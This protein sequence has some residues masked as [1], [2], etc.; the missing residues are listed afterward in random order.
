[1][2]VIVGAGLL[3]VDWRRMRRKRDPDDLAKVER[4]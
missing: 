2:V 3:A 1:M 4:S